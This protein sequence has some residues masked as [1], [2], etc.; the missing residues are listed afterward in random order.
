MDIAKLTGVL[1]SSVK[2]I[3]KM[4]EDSKKNPGLA[5]AELQSFIPPLLE[6]YREFEDTSFE[7]IK[8]AAKA[9]GQLAQVQ[10]AIQSFLSSTKTAEE[11]AGAVQAALFSNPAFVNFTNRLKDLSKFLRR[12]EKVEKVDLDEL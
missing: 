1:N 9:D 7:E 2:Q 3:K 4:T 11:R 5:L 8:S 12:G 6:S 10:H